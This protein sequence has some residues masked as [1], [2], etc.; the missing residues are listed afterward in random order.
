M[1]EELLQEENRR[2]KMELAQ[3]RRTIIKVEP[4]V[5]VDGRFEQMATAPINVI[6]V[7]R[8]ILQNLPQSE[9]ASD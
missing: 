8:Q 3:L 6:R 2:L 4:L 5:L 1:L 9:L 7:A